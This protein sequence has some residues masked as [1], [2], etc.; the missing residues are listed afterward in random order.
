MKKVYCWECGK[1]IGISVENPPRQYC[2]E[3][4]PKMIQRVNHETATWLRV[5][6]RHL[7]DEALEQL[8]DAGAEVFEYR[9]VYDE[10]LNQVLA[11][12]VRFSDVTSVK[13][14]LVLA[15]SGIEFKMLNRCVFRRADFMLPKLKIV[16]LIERKETETTWLP[17]DHML[18][19]VSKDLG[20]DWVAVRIDGHELDQHQD[21]FAHRLELLRKRVEEKREAERQPHSVK[22]PGIIA[23]YPVLPGEV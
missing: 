22:L 20:K 12:P 2:P 6:C 21:D 10:V 4:K 14:A 1:A 16:L 15:Y 17:L 23:D 18:P 7:V 13:T 3:C 9:K 5:S 19:C 8:E 11:G